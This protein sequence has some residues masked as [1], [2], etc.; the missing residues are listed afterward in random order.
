MDRW[1]IFIDIEGFSEIYKQKEERAIILLGELMRCICRVGCRVFPEHHHRIFAHQ[2]GDGF[3]IVS[4]ASVS[5]LS[6]PIAISIAIMRTMLFLHFGA[7]R[8][9]I[10]DGNFGDYYSCY[11]EE[12][13]QLKEEHALLKIGYG[14]MTISQVM[15]DALINSY[16]IQS[17]A[18]KGPCLIV[19]LRLKEYIPDDGLVIGKTEEGVIAID[20]INS[21]MGEA[22]DVIRNMGYI[23]AENSQLASRMKDYINSYQMKGEW[24][25]N[26]TNLAHPSKSTT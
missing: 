20:W 16:K 23:N 5:T 14:I 13:R 25:K 11:P 10:S 9:G 22:M 6:Q 1:S 7:T 15:G 4:Y 24:A 26:A 2:V 17:K 18:P 3:V 19:D 12:V 8:V 21:S